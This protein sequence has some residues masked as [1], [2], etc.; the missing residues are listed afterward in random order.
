MVE[1]E[2]KIKLVLEKEIIMK[3]IIAI[4]L[5]FVVFAGI[6]VF[7]AVNNYRK[8]TTPISIVVREINTTPANY[9]GRDKN[10][11]SVLRSAYLRGTNNKW[12]TDYRFAFQ[13][14]EG[15]GF[16]WERYFKNHPN[17]AVDGGLRCNVI[18]SDNPPDPK[19]F[20]FKEVAS[21]N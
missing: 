17:D 11:D 7:N 10:H 5:I 19:Y 20:K 18:F 2:I 1:T 21:T 15:S 12:E 16:N 9:L 6:V 14:P 8:Q 13:L 3:K 4:V